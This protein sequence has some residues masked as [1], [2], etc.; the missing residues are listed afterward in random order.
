[1]TSIYDARAA[2]TYAKAEAAKSRAEAE[3]LRAETARK[4]SQAAVEHERQDR[5]A[6]REERA[7]RWQRAKAQ[8]PD[9]ALAVLW[10]SVIVAPLLLAWQAQAAFA[11]ET[12]RIPVAM[13]WLFP[14]AIE[15][16]AWVC[17]FEAL[18]RSARSAP[19]GAL[20]RWMWVLAGTA[21]TINAA[22]GT[23]DHGIVAGLALGTLSL[24]GILLH[25]IRQNLTA[26]EVQGR[27]AAKVS[28]RFLRWLLFPALTL[29][30]LRVAIRTEQDA[31]GSWEAAWIDRH[32][33]GPSASKRD[34]KLA[35]T[36]A[37]RQRHQDRKAAKQGEFT[38]LNGVILR[39]ELPKLTISGPIP[40]PEPYTPVERVKLSAT[41]V[42]LLPKARAAIADGE[43]SERPSA[44]A[45]NKRFKGGMPAAQEVR[46]AL[47]DMHPVETGKEV[48]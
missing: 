42:A 22:H 17:A 3:A 29:S 36:I 39:S 14:L 37:K 19:V 25:H 6:R 38:I 12:L 8:L 7:L 35:R 41:A 5:E 46:D 2:R 28:Q 20:P 24:L 43:L 1:M 48:S 9:T 21:A 27:G 45:I 10:A 47:T 26:V 11:V 33:V 44:Y 40:E 15:A 13:S 23:A 31:A 32:G 4:N 34:R 30:A 16:G 18:R